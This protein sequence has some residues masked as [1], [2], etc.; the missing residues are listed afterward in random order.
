M[1]D[2]DTTYMKKNANDT[3]L[4]NILIEADKTSMFKLR[5]SA[6]DRGGRVM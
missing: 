6:L 4:Q 3:M 2:S 5:L 1:P